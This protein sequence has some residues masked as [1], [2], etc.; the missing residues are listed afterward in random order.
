[1][2]YRVKKKLIV[3]L[4][5]DNIYCN[6]YFGHSCNCVLYLSSCY[7]SIAMNSCCFA[8][9]FYNWNLNSQ[10]GHNPSLPEFIFQLQ[11]IRY[12][13]FWFAHSFQPHRRSSNEM[14]IKSGLLLFYFCPSN[15]NCSQ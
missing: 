9:S 8:Q 3:F 13:Y 4:C 11:L 6:L 2:I 5:R 10:R 12:G 1:M 14:K 15:N 7:L